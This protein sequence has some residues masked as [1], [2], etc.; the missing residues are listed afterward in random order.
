MSAIT[1]FPLHFLFILFYFFSALVN[2]LCPV[3]VNE[4]YGNSLE[5]IGRFL[6]VEVSQLQINVTLL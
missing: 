4:V 5:H 3:T 2:V 1:A 6:V